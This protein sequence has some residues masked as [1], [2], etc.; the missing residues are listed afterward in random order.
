M[1]RKVASGADQVRQLRD[2]ATAAFVEALINWLAFPRD[3]APAHQISSAIARV[4]ESG[5]QL[6]PNLTMAGHPRYQPPKLIP[7]FGYDCYAGWLLRVEFAILDTLC[8]VGFI[9]PQRAKL[10]TE[11]VRNKLLANVTTTM[12]DR[13]E[14]GDATTKGTGHDIEAL[15]LAC[16]Q[17][18]PRELWNDFHFAATSWD[19]VNTAYALMHRLSYWEV[20]RPQ[21]QEWGDA[22]AER[23]FYYADQVMLGRTHGQPANPITVGHWL[24]YPLGRLIDTRAHLDQFANELVGKFSGPVGASNALVAFGLDPLYIEGEVL[25]KLGLN[26]P[27]ISTQI[28]T[29]EQIS[30]YLQ[31]LGQLSGVMDQLATDIRLLYMPEIGEVGVAT[32]DFDPATTTG[33]STM[34][35]KRNPIDA[36]NAGGMHVVVSAM[37]GMLPSLSVSWLQRD[38]TGSSVMRFLP[39]IPV[40]ASCA[41]DKMIK[42]TKRLDINT[43]RARANLEGHGDIIISELFQLALKRYGYPGD[44]HRLT[45]ELVS[46]AKESGCSLYATIQHRSKSGLD[47]DLEATWDKLILNAELN[48]LLQHPSE[49]IGNAASNAR[50]II[51]LWQE[52]VTV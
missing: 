31:E 39:A 46:T 22:L 26:A 16:G 14:R 11:E 42:I 9:P 24:A 36:E 21:I 32:L 30:R 4:L 7:Y 3:A 51:R 27:L 28:T 17:F 37:L 15:K 43:E 2:Q 18:L 41:L 25:T 20:I 5:I 13:W 12:M 23:T 47:T 40:C 6:E 19:I 8:E 33:S 35:H 48:H 52:Q 1:A 49:Y 34:S 38:L 29:P 45:N 10:F 50:W 44:A